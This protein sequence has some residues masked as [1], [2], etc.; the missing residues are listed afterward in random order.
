M[1]ERL[2]ELR[3]TLGIKIV[4]TFLCIVAAAIAAHYLFL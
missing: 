2:Y 1:K 4:L 3:P